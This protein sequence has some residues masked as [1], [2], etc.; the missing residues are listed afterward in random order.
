M[1]L[2]TGPR[3]PRVPVAVYLCTGET[4]TVELLANYCH[5][6]A[7]AREWTIHDTVH[8]PDR[9]QQLAE[10]PG[11]AQ[12]FAAV[13]GGEV[14]GIVTLSLP[15]VAAGVDGSPDWESYSALRQTIAGLGGFLIAIR[16]DWHLD[17][18]RTGS[19]LARRHTLSTRAAG[20]E[21]P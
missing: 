9:R 17:V 11:W 12:V 18:R 3:R 8:D 20:W 4:D 5:Q 2:A 21:E 13:R 16:A 6:Y 19:E 10:R 1:T 15:M 14:S 7:R